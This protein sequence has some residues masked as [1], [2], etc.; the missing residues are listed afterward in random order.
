MKPLV[1][2]LTLLL[3][4][5]ASVVMGQ[6]EEQTIPGYPAL[7]EV[8]YDYF[9]GSAR[10]MGMGFA[11]V[12]LANDVSGG[13]WNPAG[14][15]VLDGP[16]ISASYNSYLPAGIFNHSLTDKTTENNIDL[17]GIGHFS[18]V[19][20][21]RIKGHP[22]VF[23]FNY[24]RHND[25]SV[26]TAYQAN[27]F[28]ELDPDTFVEDIGHTRIFNAG[29]STR[30]Y[31]QLSMGFTINIIDARRVK[32]EQYQIRETVIIDPVYGTTGEFFRSEQT[33]DSTTS[34]G[35]NFTLG[36]M[37]KGDK[38]SIGAVVH[39]PYTMK[40][41]SDRSIYEVQKFNDLVQLDYTSTTFV[42]DSLAKQEVP[43]SG[44]IGGAIFPREDVTLAMDLT[45]QNYASTNWFYLDS[46]FFAPNGERTD[47]Y[48]EFPIDWNNTIGI[49]L[50]AEYRWGTGFGTIPLRAG[51]RF[52]Q[53]PEP[54]NFSLLY[55]NVNYDEAGNPQSEK[56]TYDVTRMASD[57]R[58]TTSI[59]LG[60]GLSWSRIELDFAY[61]FTSGSETELTET[62]ETYFEDDEGNPEVLVTGSKFKWED[63]EH[64]FRFTFTG[65]F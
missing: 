34:N 22:W 63:E 58:N 44:T 36:L 9:G 4:L 59:S 47:F 16:M 26:E 39:T 29:A 33:I 7:N 37:Y 6:S 45:F 48:T 49:G 61:M 40:H 5:G 27:P 38:Y 32:D 35:F 65:Y 56:D 23:N 62:T 24:N 42:V 64:Q 21:V 25:Y 1:G 15:W 43:L 11:F 10:A 46:S 13:I 20:P 50:G 14:L 2:L 51:F 53:Q 12:G 30:L 18:F 28:N 31:K 3:L 54:K 8:S 52:D 55:S 17:S 41:S 57:R 60:T 19:A